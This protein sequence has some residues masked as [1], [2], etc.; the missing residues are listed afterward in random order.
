MCWVESAGCERKRCAT[1]RLPPRPSWP[2]PLR[3]TGLE[4]LAVAAVCQRVENDWL[5][6][7]VGVADAVCALVGEPNTLLEVRCEPCTAGGSIRLPE[8][9]L[10]L[11][12]DCGVTLPDAAQ[13][14]AHV[15][16]ATFMGRALIERIIDA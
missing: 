9:L 4:P 8:D 2:A 3:G 10:L 15:R 7:P 16:T 12:V 13:R 14:Y 11:G 1:R 5:G 6:A